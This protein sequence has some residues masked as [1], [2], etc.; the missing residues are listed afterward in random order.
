MLNPAHDFCNSLISNEVSC[1]SHGYRIE[2]L[3]DIPWIS[4][5]Y[6]MDIS[7]LSHSAR[8]PLSQQQ[9]ARGGVVG[10]AVPTPAHAPRRCDSG[11]ASP[12]QRWRW[13]ASASSPRGR[14]LA[15]TPSTGAMAHGD[16]APVLAAGASAR[17]LGGSA[18][19]ADSLVLLIAWLCSMGTCGSARWPPDGAA[20]QDV[21]A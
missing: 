18:G 14:R 11:D 2:Y 17:R 9:A 5:A 4:H 20:G 10:V 15:P 1:I 6:P 21:V 3:M 8:M 19:T 7:W 13:A 12:G 16:A